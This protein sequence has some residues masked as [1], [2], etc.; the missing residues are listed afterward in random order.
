MHPPDNLPPG[1]ARAR[2]L[3]AESLGGNSSILLLS[4]RG[5]LFSGDDHKARAIGKA[6]GLI[7]E[8]R[9][10]LGRVDI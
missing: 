4:Y 9:A 3:A 7:K 6:E 1:G 2:Q 5:R 10:P 8:L